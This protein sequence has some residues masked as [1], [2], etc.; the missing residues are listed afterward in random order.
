MF[1]VRETRELD[2]KGR[3]Q[4]RIGFT[5]TTPSQ[6]VANR[7]ITVRLSSTTGPCEVNDANKSD[8]V[9]VQK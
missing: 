7:E 2:K 9:H 3:Y 5:A 8:T 4:G 1:H 6:V